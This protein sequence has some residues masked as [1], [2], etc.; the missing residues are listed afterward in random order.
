MPPIDFPD[1][2]ILTGI[3]VT[4]LVD[5]SLVLVII[6]MV[7]APFVP[8]LLKPIHLPSSY[9]AALTEA[10]CIKVSLFSDGR[11]AVDTD[12]VSRE[13]LEEAV[14]SKIASGHAPW[15]IIR[16]GSEASHGSVM[17]IVDIVKRAGAQRIAFAVQSQARSQQ[18]NP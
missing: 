6:F 13:S 17:Q 3:N 16:A 15:V 2:E 14:K 10:D 7:I 8:Q 5:V 9:N 1:D 4:P 12:F 11:I 18:K